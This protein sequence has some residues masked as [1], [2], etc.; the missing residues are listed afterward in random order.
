MIS[1]LTQTAA[2]AASDVISAAHLSMKPG[3][4]QT[5]RAFTR[6]FDSQGQFKT[7][8]DKEFCL[9]CMPSQD[10]LIP[11]MDPNYAFSNVLYDVLVFLRAPGN[12]GLWITGPAGSGKTSLVKQAAARLAWPVDEI[13]LSDRSEASSLIGQMQL[14]A[15]GKGGTRTFFQYGPLANAMKLGHILLLN[16]IDLLDAGE[17]MALNGALDGSALTI[18]ETGEVIKPHPMFRLIMTS[19]TAGNGDDSGRYQGTKQ[20]NF[21]SGDRVRTLH[22]GYPPVPVEIALV[23]Q[24]NPQ[25]TEEIASKLVQF[26]ND[27]RKGSEADCAVGGMTVTMSTRTL[28]RWARLIFAYHC[29]KCPLGYA[30]GVALLNRCT[31]TDQETLKSNFKVVFGEEYQQC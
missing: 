25:I 26:A 20:M 30:L 10:P 31:S 5:S 17:T 14:Q 1:T 19:N 16:E 12:D 27:V 15:D 6:I 4:Y 28:L 23:R 29:K 13:T 9:G 21:A 18:P 7:L 8:D 24:V 3:K 22:V 2:P 11:P